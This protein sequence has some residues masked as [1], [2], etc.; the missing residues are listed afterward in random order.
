MF[1]G[2]IQPTHL[3]IAMAAI[4][5]VWLFVRLVRNAWKKN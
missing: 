1:D 4:G 5:F 3:A 2:L